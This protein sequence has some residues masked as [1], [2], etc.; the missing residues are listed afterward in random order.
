MPFTF[1][2]PVVVVP[3]K[4]RFSQWFNLTALVVGSMS[5]DFEYFL[6]LKTHTQISHTWI[7]IIIFNLPIV[8][9]VSLLFHQVVKGPLLTHLPRPLSTSFGGAAHQRW[10]TFTPRNVLIFLYSALIGILSHLLWDSF[11]HANGFFVSLIPSLAYQVN[12]LGLAVPVYKFLQHGSTI[13]G[14]LLLVCFLKA[15]PKRTE[16]SLIH[17][18][19]SSTQKA[20]YW[21]MVVITALALSVIRLTMW[22]DVLGIKMIIG[23]MVVTVISA[24]ML[25][26]LLASIIVRYLRA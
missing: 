5:P 7:G 3:L 8:L 23:T 12:F 21:S 25:G 4:R 6:R 20:C 13:V 18:I 19:V 11:T 26:I 22:D 24:G 14:L 17:E 16:F 9:I 10:I 2:H 1:A 15:C